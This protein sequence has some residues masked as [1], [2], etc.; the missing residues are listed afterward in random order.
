MAKK[1]G[2]TILAV[3]LATALAACGDTPA[4]EALRSLAPSATE[5]EAGAPSPAPQGAGLMLLAPR[6]VLLVPVSEAGDRRVWRGVGNVALATEGA[7][8]VATAGLARMVMATRFDGPDPLD[9][10]R[11]LL[12]REARARRTVDL[13]GADREPGSMR[14]GVALDCTLRGQPEAG[15]ILV[16]ERCRGGGLSFT[17]RFWAEAASG[18][19]RRSEQW[20][21]DGL[22]LLVIE[23]R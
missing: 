4:G 11:A 6:R 9:D 23:I 17:N 22:P 10:P 15:W 5:T 3:S 18:T 20:A 19:V 2:L 16:E 12:G 14:F 21:G 8:V 7:R 1:P 13:S